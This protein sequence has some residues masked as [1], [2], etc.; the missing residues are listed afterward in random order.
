[1]KRFKDKSVLVTGAASGI[2][3]AAS[4]RFAEE[5]AQ[6]LCADVQ[7]EGLTETVDSITS[8]GGIAASRLCDIRDIEAVR[9]TV[10]AVVG[11]YGKLDVLFNN[12][13][14]LDGSHFHSYPTERWDKVIAVNLTGTFLMCREAIPHL[15]ETKGNI[16]NMA[17]SSALSG[18]PYVAAYASS[19]GGIIALTSTLAIEYALSGLRVN[20]VCPAHIE[21]QM[22]SEFKLPEG[23]SVK[24]L[25]RHMSL[26]KAAR[27]PH[28]VAG[29]VA[30]LASEDAEHVNGEIIR[31]DGGALS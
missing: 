30:F 6:V 3:R 9:K 26:D 28:T 18:H 8:R 12:A 17:S 10:S 20:A 19:K 29:V 7:S 14:I 13:G 15:L 25:E 16:V 22:A 5:G 11:I 21:T 4:Q 27:G 31:V 24:M 2:G 1:M 23:G